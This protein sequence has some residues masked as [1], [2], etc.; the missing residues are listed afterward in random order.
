LGAASRK[1]VLRWKSALGRGYFPLS[2]SAGGS[3]LRV[4]HAHCSFKAVTL[5]LPLSGWTTRA[6]A[7]HQ[8]M[9]D[10]MGIPKLIAKDGNP[11]NTRPCPLIHYYEQLLEDM[12][13][14][15]THRF[16]PIH[17]TILNPIPKT[18]IS[19]PPRNSRTAPP[20]NSSSS[21]T[22]DR[23]AW[24]QPKSAR[25]KKN[26]PSADEH[27]QELAKD[28]H[29]SNKSISNPYEHEDTE[30][31]NWAFDSLLSD[32]KKDLITRSRKLIKL[33]TAGDPPKTYVKRRTNKL[34]DD[35]VMIALA[36]APPVFMVF[37]EQQSRSMMSL[38]YLILNSSLMT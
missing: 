29:E 6:C 34:R 16:E 11:L 30:Q 36:A 3:V 10:M 23:Y 33:I 9:H 20:N 12:R 13:H 4:E 14:I 26:T 37:V 15:I 21:S 17:R 5:N 31:Y 32:E 24:W 19:S 27:F 28:M 8:T 18:T 25:S 2:E 35:L 22:H 38:Q 1:M 7:K